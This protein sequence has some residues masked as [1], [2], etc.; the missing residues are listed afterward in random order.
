MNGRSRQRGRAQNA[1][2]VM[3][4][5]ISL[6]RASRSELAAQLGLDR[7]T[8]THITSA[9]L[10]ARLIEA[11]AE[12]PAGS[13]GG[14]RAEL[15]SVERSRYSI[16]SAEVR[17]RSVRWLLTDLQGE[18]LADGTLG[19]SMPSAGGAVR[20]SWM[21]GVLADLRDIVRSHPDGRRVLGVGLA[22]P[23]LFD[24]SRSRLVESFELGLSDLDIASV[25]NCDDPPLRA[26]N[27]AT[28]YAWREIAACRTEL[29]RGETTAADGVYVYTK[30]H[31]DGERFLPT[32][33]GVGVIVVAEGR[34]LRGHRG[35][36]GELRGYG[37]T[38]RDADQLGVDL[39]QIRL[40]DGQQ[41]AVNAAATELI[42]N[43][44]VI[45]SLLDPPR[46]VVAG[47]LGALGLEMRRL[48][49]DLVPPGQ[50][51]IAFREPELLAVAH[52]AAQMVVETL[53]SPE[54]PALPLNELAGSDNR[55]TE[56]SYGYA[57]VNTL[58]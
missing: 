46:I 16:L 51:E 30:L 22:L 52:G 23:G 9:L 32:G 47:D 11:V 19:P 36:A 7:S 2:A 35:A 24:R 50:V 39:E 3:R 49:A 41:A 6:G 44:V 33:M 34:I 58:Q 8:M 20:R 42:R 5:L 31:T 1:F 55:G 43:L 53:F 26:A 25:W 12:A 14:R 56:F 27:D 37:Y 10:A 48:A 15:L 57:R 54:S 38:V 28:C 13:R 18:P 4:A 17:S 21:E 40:R 29:S 45:S